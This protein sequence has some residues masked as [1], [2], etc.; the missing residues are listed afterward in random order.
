MHGD[1]LVVLFGIVY[2][3]PEAAAIT[4]I[5]ERRW[6]SLMRR[7]GRYDAGTSA[8]RWRSTVTTACATWSDVTGS[9]CLT[10]SVST[11]AIARSASMSPPDAPGR[12]LSWPL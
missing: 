9:P 3:P 4:W 11:Q 12:T 8:C 10:A 1:L 6:V 2:K 7:A 5:G